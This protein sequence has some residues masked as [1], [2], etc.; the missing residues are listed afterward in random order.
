MTAPSTP[1]FGDDDLSAALDGEIVVGLADH[2][3]GCAGCADRSTR[4][5]AAARLIGAVSDVE[6]PSEARV[7]AWILAATEES[8]GA[9]PAVGAGSSTESPTVVRLRWPPATWLVAAAA[10]IVFLAG[11]GA[12]VRTT[13]GSDTAGMAMKASGDASLP[14]TDA[15]AGAGQSTLAAD[16]GATATDDLGDQPTTDALV[17]ALQANAN[18][19][20]AGGSTGGAPAAEASGEATGARA[21]AATDSAAASAA[22]AAP[23]C[24]AEAE[25]IGADRLGPLEYVA[26]LRFAGQPAE[27]L[28]FVLRQPA[29]GVSRQALVLARPG[30]ALLA[31]PRF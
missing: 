23:T 18:R 1:H 31:D 5:A 13:A 17:A 14:M 2:L 10:A 8:S 11:L 15:N 20:A 16:A 22:P 27:V 7:D 26:T 21:G 3:A 25:R 24:R 9:A 30:C 6:A 28:V 29:T 19:A 4:L 12:L